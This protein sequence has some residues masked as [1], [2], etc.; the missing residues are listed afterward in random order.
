[1]PLKI[2]RADITKLKADAIVNA[3]NSRLLGG[4]GVDG[5]I[6]KV[7]GEGLLEECRCIGG[8]PVGEVRL[9]GGYDLPAKY[10]IHTVGPVWK[11]GN[12]KEE[13][14]LE[15][16]YRNSLEL[17]LNLGLESIAFPLIA[18]GAYGYPKEKALETA[19]ETIS[20]FLE[21]HEMLVSLVVYDKGAYA[22][23]K[24]L[25]DSVKNYINENYMADIDDD[26]LDEDTYNQ[27]SRFESR[28]IRQSSSID[29]T[30]D[31]S[32]KVSLKPRKIEDLL[33]T[34]QESFS[35]HLLHRIDLSGKT[36]VEVYK[37]AN[38]DRKLFSKIR[39]DREYKPR[40]TTALA[41]AIGLE[42]NLDETKDLLQKAG[43]ALS[44]SSEADLIVEYF[45]MEENY[46]IHL[47]N[48]VLFDHDLA[49]LGMS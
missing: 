25:F 29:Y 48:E 6:H 10:V 37:N 24:V 8:C 4:G 7:A 42:L 35:E 40:K 21:K 23:S 31:Y 19:V 32:A 12:S 15:S 43:F 20:K 3:A 14:L 17:A 26:D 2:I 47:I 18:A 49:L 13:E 38:I 28:E 22:I 5:A 41:L 33:K 45:I 16:C 36:D 30:E 1:M 46:N 34:V 9:T 39:S 44:K 27:I 11:G